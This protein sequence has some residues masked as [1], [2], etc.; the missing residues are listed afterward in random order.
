FG[1]GSISS[2]PT[3]SRAS[4]SP[5]GSSGTWVLQSASPPSSFWLAFSSMG[6]QHS[7]RNWKSLYLQPFP[8]IRKLNLSLSGIALCLSMASG[9]PVLH[10]QDSTNFPTIGEV[11]RLDPALDELLDKDAVIEVLTSGFTWTEGPVWVKDPGHPQEG[12][13]LFSDIPNNRVVR[14][15][16]GVGASTWMQPSGYTGV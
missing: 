15:E 9:Y 4:S 3:G 14:W 10:A 13:L 5:A 16:E 2:S 8:I 7:I 11:I 12:Y 6:L 1:E